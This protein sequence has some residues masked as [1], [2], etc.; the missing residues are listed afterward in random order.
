MVFWAEREKNRQ[1]NT[2]PLVSTSARAEPQRLTTG[3]FP[4]LLQQMSCCWRLISLQAL[5][6]IMCTAGCRHLEDF[7]CLVL[8]RKILWDA[9]EGASHGT[10]S[11]TRLFLY[12]WSVYI[13]THCIALHLLMW[14]KNSW[15]WC[16]NI[17]HF[18]HSFK[19]F[20]IDSC[21]LARILS[22]FFIKAL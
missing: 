15:C 18:L 1:W 12:S 17:Q 4:G 19:T 8:V 9:N 6:I 11:K 5:W 22:F 2:E 3:Y 10:L 20:V 21:F 14:H 13:T 16:I 7:I